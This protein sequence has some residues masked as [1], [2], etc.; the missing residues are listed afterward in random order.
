MAVASPGYDQVLSSRF[1]QPCV[2][3]F[4]MVVMSGINVYRNG[5]QGMG[6]GFLP[7]TAGI[8]ELAGRGLTAVVASHYK[9]YLGIC[10]ASPVAWIFASA[11]L[12]VMY[13]GIMNK[14]KKA[15]NFRE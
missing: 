14:Y 10:L 8:A 7:M 5:I 13:F 9:S 3:F 6:Y 11:L 2:Q 15:G 1:L 4:I 12:L